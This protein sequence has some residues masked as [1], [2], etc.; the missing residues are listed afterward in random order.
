MNLATKLALFF[1]MSKKSSNFVH[2]DR[3][4]I[5]HNNY[6]YSRLLCFEHTNKTSLF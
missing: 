6:E 2:A 5:M 1:D 3:K 4:C